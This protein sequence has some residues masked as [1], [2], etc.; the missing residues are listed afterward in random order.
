MATK[1][2]KRSETESWYSEPVRFVSF[3]LSWLQFRFWGPAKQCS[4]SG[5]ESI[6]VHLRSSVVFLPS[7]AASPGNLR[8]DSFGYLRHLRNLR[9]SS[10]SSSPSPGNLR[11][12]CNLWM[13]SLSCLRHL[14]LHRVWLRPR[15][16]ARVQYRIQGGTSCSRGNSRYGMIVCV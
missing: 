16:R 7:S 13:A 3:V 10:L 2:R 12:L 9:F 11:N 6:C 1:S 8:T 5:R 14:R 4:G 15:G